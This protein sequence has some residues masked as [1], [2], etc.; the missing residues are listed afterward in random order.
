MPLSLVVDGAG[1]GRDCVS[2]CGVSGSWD[3]G[4]VE[5]LQKNRMLVI[6]WADVLG[7]DNK[8]ERRGLFGSIGRD[9]SSAKER[10]REW[11]SRPK[12]ECSVGLSSG[13]GE[14]PKQ[15]RSAVP[16]SR[17]WL[18]KNGNIRLVSPATGP[19]QNLWKELTAPYG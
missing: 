1:V 13:K 5:V 15:G 2:W 3:R 19:S 11:R 8:A 9:S 16:R 10:Q 7:I 4:K 18:E 17:S 14:I 12:T 6:H